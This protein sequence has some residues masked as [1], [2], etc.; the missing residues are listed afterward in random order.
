MHFKLLGPIEVWHED[1]PIPMGSGRQRF[2]LALLLLNADRLTLSDQLVDALWDEPPPTTKAQL[3]NMISDLRRRLRIGDSDLIVTHSSGYEL[4]L[5]S[6]ALDLTRFR[7][8]VELGKNA[9]STGEHSHAATLLSEALS[10]WR[11]PA[12]ADVHRDPA[13]IIR[14]ALHEEHLTAREVRL[15]VEMVLGRYDDVLQEL[16]TLIVEYPYRERLHEI[17]MAALAGM[18]QRADALAAY[19]QVYEQFTDD[20]GVPPGP[21]L[22]R[23]HQEIL[24]GRSAVNGRAHL[25]KPRQLPPA[26]TVMVGR[27]ELLSDICASLQQSGDASVPSALLAGPGGV[28][29]TTLALAIAHQVAGAFPDGLLYADLRGSQTAATD[30]HA[31]I[32]RFLR[33]LGVDGSRLPDDHEERIAVYRSH[34]AQRRMLMVL[35]DAASEQQV[36]PLMPGMAACAVV[37]TSRHRL[38][39]LVGTTRWTIPL[40]AP[41]DALRLLTAL[42]GADRAKREPEAAAAIMDLCGHLP[43]AVCVA[44]GRLAARVEWKLEE[45]RQRLAEERNRL[46]ELAVG[47]LDVRASIALSYQALDS[48]SRTLFRRLGLMSAPDWPGWVAERLI[49]PAARDDVERMLDQLVDTH[50]IEPLGQDAIGLPRFRLH[51]LIADFARER[52]HA[53]EEPAVRTEL[54]TRVISD[55]LVLAIAA[56]Q[57]L[58]HGVVSADGPRDSAVQRIS[59]LVRQKPAEWFE[60]ERASLVSA[61]DVACRLGDAELAGRLALSL[62]GFLGMRSYDDDREHTLRQTIACVRDHVSDELL[63]RLLGELFAV[64]AQRDRYAELPALAT[65]E[66][67]VAQ[68]LRDLHGQFQALTHAGRAARLLGRYHEA[69]SWFEQAL[70][71][72]R[73]SGAA[74]ELVSRAL[75][76]YANLHADCGRPAMALPLLEEAVAIACAE[77]NVRLFAQQLHRYGNCLREVGRLAEAEHAL[78][79]ALAATRRI[80]DGRGS[81]WV[82]H[83]LAELDMRSARWRDAAK[84]LDHSLLVMRDVGDEEGM[85]EVLRSLGDLSVGQGSLEN[86]LDPL[87]QSLTIWRKLDARLQLARTIM[88][89]NRVLRAVG[90][91]ERSADF[92]REGHAIL[93]E[94]GLDENCLGLP[95]FFET[96]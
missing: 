9:V 16:A 68:C 4:R 67:Q 75:Y 43:L 14:Q 11:G 27:D 83:A 89:F 86:A 31:A 32:G 69:T 84:R 22:Q 26:S 55:W 76:A 21:S 70:A 23:L 88:R 90:E 65:E 13:A 34:L 7:R 92:H 47:D 45:F 61:V 58:G 73:H 63:M 57:Q 17:R 3:H 40:L 59:S 37:I 60:A 91:F 12:L 20:L 64:C 74:P 53:E 46:D 41:D 1:R 28:G 66:L 72:A 30:P 79:E 35:D 24:A 49:E 94:L 42:V 39:A 18:G 71:A 85:A 81:A 51:D 80:G 44:A 2:V 5:G 96:L 48:R 10:L 50:L 15:D 95:A 36:R 56:D 6:H 52:A 62:T 33:T 78:G 19:R 38:G 82:E 29:K 77:G 25:P 87:H 93:T 54:L 8:L